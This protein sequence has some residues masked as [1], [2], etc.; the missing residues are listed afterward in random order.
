MQ[1]R[2]QSSN[3]PHD[4]FIKEFVPVVLKNL[5][6][7]QTSV[8]VQLSE[9]LAIDVLCIAKDPDR[10]SSDPSLGL[11]GRLVNIHP[12]IIIEHLSTVSISNN[13][14][15]DYLKRNSSL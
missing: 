2:Q 14:K 1:E 9:K 13:F 5:F 12:T 11:L 15:S 3:D 6:D 4:K 7:S 8:S 10:S